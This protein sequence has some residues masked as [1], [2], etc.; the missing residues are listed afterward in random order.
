M[1][2]VYFPVLQHK[3]DAIAEQKPAKKQHTDVG[4]L[5]LS[6][7]AHDARTNFSFNAH[8]YF[9]FYLYKINVGIRD[10]AIRRMNENKMQL[11]TMRKRVERHFI[12]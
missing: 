4:L 9:G 2:N 7:R 5:V 3:Q 6:W 12:D 11:K 8:S 10:D 1:S